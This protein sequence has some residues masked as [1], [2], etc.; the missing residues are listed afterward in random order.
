MDDELQ[1]RKQLTF[2]QAE[3][4]AELPRQLRRDEM[5]KSLRAKLFDAI[6][7]T[8]EYRMEKQKLSHYLPTGWDNAFRTLW[9]DRLGDL[10]PAFD[11]SKQRNFTRLQ[12]LFSESKHYEVYGIV[13]QLIRSARDTAFTA[14]VERIL[15]EEHSAFRLV[16]GDTLVPFASERDA[17]TVLNSLS[18]MER[19]GFK[20]ARQHLKEAATSLSAGNFADSIRESI[21]SV[22]AVVRS[23]TGEASLA[24][25]LSVLNGR[26][27]MHEAFRQ[28]LLKLYGFSS[29]EKGI[30]HPLIDSEDAAVTEQDAIFILGVCSGFNS[31]FTNTFHGK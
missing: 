29:D 4:F 17:E 21:H 7:R 15:A 12:Q 11:I 14:R 28:S 26:R 30:R 5:P 31:Y 24:K 9:V 10:S 13:Q 19:A 2:E 16:D 22:E 1:R 23:L 3:G 20:G 25:A 8:V 27:A 18:D 6:N